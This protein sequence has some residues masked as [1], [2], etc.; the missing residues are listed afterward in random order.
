MHA[1]LEVPVKEESDNEGDNALSDNAQSEGSDFEPPPKRR[2]STSK[3]TAKTR[4][5]RRSSVKGKQ[6]A[7]SEIEAM[8]EDEEH[9][10]ELP[11]H[12]SPHSRPQVEDDDSDDDELAIGAEVCCYQGLF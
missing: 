9:G 7:R 4:V 8:D 5:R 6:V 1:V 3:G 12:K 2:T 10:E 11:M